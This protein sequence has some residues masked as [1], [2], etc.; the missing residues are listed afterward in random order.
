M[1]LGG[2]ILL[3]GSLLIAWQP[4]LLV[5]AYVSMFAGFI[6][7]NRGM[8]EVGKWTRNPRNDQILDVRMKGLSDRV[9]LIHYAPVGKDRIEHLAVHP[10]GVAVITARETDGPVTKRGNRWTRK[11]GTFRRIFSF[12][13]PQLGNP[14]LDT[15]K[16]V[17]QLQTYL[18]EHDISAEI[19]GA[20]AFIHPS[21]TLDIEDPDYPVLHGDELE[22][23]IKDIGADPGFT[24]DERKRLIGVLSQGGAEEAT[25]RD[26]MSRRPRPVKRVSAPKT[27]SQAVPA[28]KSARPRVKAK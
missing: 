5:I 9:T 15:D 18:E 28:T 4:N 21:V 26:Q 19:D 7:F 23:F 12:S 10:G 3:A 20:I 24:E 11:G 14:S 1:A 27:P 2:F 22:A 6:I 25:S 8:Q 16:S 13:G 17:A